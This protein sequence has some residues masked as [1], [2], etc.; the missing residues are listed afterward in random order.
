MWNY[1]IAGLFCR[2]KLPQIVLK[3]DFDGEN[4]CGF[5]VTQFATSTNVA[6]FSGEV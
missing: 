3:I 5:V 2:R 4:L 1:C 6:S